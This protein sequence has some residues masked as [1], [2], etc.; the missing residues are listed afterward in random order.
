MTEEED[1]PEEEYYEEE[2]GS[3]F[4][5][6]IQSMGQAVREE[7]S[8]MWKHL[9]DRPKTEEANRK[10]VSR[11]KQRTLF[12]AFV[13]YLFLTNWFGSEPFG[14]GFML[15]VGFLAILAITVLFRIEL[16]ARVINL[17]IRALYGTNNR[18]ANWLFLFATVG[19]IQTF[20]TDRSELV[21]ASTAII[22][23]SEPRPEQETDA[24][25][26]MRWKREYQEQKERFTNAKQGFKTNKELEI[27]EVE[28]QTTPI[29]KL[30]VRAITAII[31]VILCPF[32]LIISRTDEASHWSHKLFA[33]I[34][35]RLEDKTKP[36]ASEATATG[37]GLATAAAAVP[38]VVA[39]GS[40][41]GDA[42]QRFAGQ[43]ASEI[44]AEK[45]VSGRKKK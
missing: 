32:Y 14:I 7:G 44:I 2:Q 41:V 15:V 26:T 45:L 11:M 10:Q 35:S 40:K 24:E 23:K 18:L 27:L 1:F 28:S 36:V 38:V 30:D 9:T 25:R 39:A 17:P 5:Y 33:W 42:V 19:V 37:T 13:M 22:K 16:L 6:R 31:L 21:Q 4:W 43:V 34:F 12:A 20:R 8:R 3:G 29:R